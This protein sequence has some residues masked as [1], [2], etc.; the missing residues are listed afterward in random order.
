MNKLT[1]KPAMR[2]PK[3]IAVD[4]EAGPFDWQFAPGRSIPGYGFNGQVPGPTIEGNVGDTLVVQLRNGLPEP[5]T[6]HWHG[7]RVPAEMDGTERV[8]R[9]VQPG[10]TFE[11]RFVLPDAGTFW[12]HPHLNINTTQQLEKG[13]YGAMVVRGPGEPT[14]D[15]E[16]VL[17]LDDIKLDP[18]GNLAPF[19]D[20]ME[21][22]AGRKGDTLLVNGK[23]GAELNM[24]AGQIQRWRIVNASSARYIRLSIGDLQFNILATD[25]GLVTAPVPAGEVLL[26]PGD[27]VDIALGPFD[28][29]EVVAVQTLGEEGGMHPEEGASYATLKVGPF[30]ESQA[31]LPATLREIRP[32][33]SGEPT[34]SRTIHLGVRSSGDLPPVDWQIDGEANYQDEPVRVGDLQVWDIVNDT[35]M[36]HPFHLHGFFFQ[37][38]ET[39]GE[40]PPFLS[41]EDTVDIPTKGRVRIAWLPD[42]RPGGW[43]YHCHILEHAAAGMM[44]HF[45]VVPAS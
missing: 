29:D 39:N 12:Y 23:T 41:W 5:T 45:E 6:I 31:N 26:T 27:R 7:L 8:Q 4:L 20:R 11:Y 43:M 15:G 36:A 2:S 13:L 10:D 19:G 22:H 38:L 34:V 33:V 42:D 14:L 18:D 32:L 30:A 16:Q 25:G 17:V 21:R 44:G 37:V 3:T 35:E 40:H 9:P 1:E 28:E 24:H